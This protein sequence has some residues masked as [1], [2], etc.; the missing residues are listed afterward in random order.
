MIRKGLKGTG[1]FVYLQVVRRREGTH[2]FTFA[3]VCLAGECE[4]TLPYEQS[5]RISQQAGRQEKGGEEGEEMSGWSVE[6]LS[7]VRREALFDLFALSKCEAHA[8]SAGS[9]FSVIGRL[10]AGEFQ[11]PP[12]LPSCQLKGMYPNWKGRLWRYGYCPL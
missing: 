7:R 3:P 8:G 10:W 9:S 4:L 6:A 5:L 1:A 11:P 12:P 2:S